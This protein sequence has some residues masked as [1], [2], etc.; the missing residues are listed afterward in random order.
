[1]D[2]RETDIDIAHR[3][4]TR[5]QN[6]RRGQRKRSM[7]RLILYPCQSSSVVTIRV[8]FRLIVFSLVI[9]HLRKLSPSKTIPRLISDSLCKTSLST[10]LFSSTDSR[11]CKHEMTLKSPMNEPRT[12][13]SHTYM[14]CVKNCSVTK[15]CYCPLRKKE[16]TLTRPSV[17]PRIGWTTRAGTQLLT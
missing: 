4:P 16:R 15:E 13:S 9:F 6:G 17:M 8:C 10:I 1:M 2:V 7:A 14:T 5:K 11:T 3:I 12:C